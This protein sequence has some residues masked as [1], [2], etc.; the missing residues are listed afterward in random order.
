MSPLTP[1]TCRSSA[2]V[3]SAPRPWPRSF[4]PTA[5]ASTECDAAGRGAKGGLEHHRVVDVATSDL[6]VGRGVDR[7]V[8]GLVV[9]DA[10]EHRWAV[11]AGEA[12]PVDRSGAAHE[13]GRMTVGQQ[14]VVGDWSLA[15]DDF[16]L[17]SRAVL[18]GQVPNS[19]QV[20]T[21][22]LRSVRSMK[23]NSSGPAISGGASCTIGSPR[24]SVR[25]M[26]PAS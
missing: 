20:S 25:Q 17:G 2:D 18:H 23:S 15:H 8:T 9:E 1:V 7:P 10:P 22:T 14:R 26:R 21:S 13:R 16:V 6:G 4:R 24:S 5:S 19:F 11:E 3:A 12:Q